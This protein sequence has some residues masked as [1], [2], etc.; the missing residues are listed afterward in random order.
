MSMDFI[1]RIEK[2]SPLDY[3]LLCAAAH[4]YQENGNTS[5]LPEIKRLLDK[6]G[7]KYTDDITGGE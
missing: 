5:V 3:F 2:E 6:H 4:D 7:V 1:D